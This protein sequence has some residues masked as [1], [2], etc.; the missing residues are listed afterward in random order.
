MAKDDRKRMIVVSVAGAAVTLLV[1]LSLTIGPTLIGCLADRDGL[2]A[3]L[4]QQSVERGLLPPGSADSTPAA[5]PIP[6]GAADN[7]A[8][9][10]TAPGNAQFVRGTPIAAPAR[11]VL[12]EGRATG[13]ARPVGQAAAE[14]AMV[15][16]KLIAAADGSL[17]SDIRRE[18]I[19]QGHRAVAVL[20][21]PL[22][23]AAAMGRG[24][25]GMPGRLVEDVRGA[26]ILVPP[27]SR[28]L[29]SGRYAAVSVPVAP[30]VRASATLPPRRLGAA[31]AE[32]RVRLGALEGSV[33][34]VAGAGRAVMAL[35]RLRT[36]EVSGSER[37]D[38]RQMLATAR[39]GGQAVLPRPIL[40]MGHVMSDAEAVPAPVRIRVASTMA[41]PMPRA[42]DGRAA[43][44][45]PSTVRAARIAGVATVSRLLLPATG[46]VSSAT[47]RVL[48]E[49]R[50]ESVRMPQMPPPPLPVPLTTPSVGPPTPSDA[51]PRVPQ[52]SEAPVTRMAASSGQAPVPAERSR[53]LVGLPETQR[54]IPASYAV[55]RGD[56]LWGISR[57]AYGAGRHYDVIF[58]ANRAV[59]SDPNLIF[60]GQVLVI[61]DRFGP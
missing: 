31:R 55:I 10:S 23:Q 54:R 25:F 40:A 12:A 18:A 15:M 56:T 5:T 48:T 59:I 17:R 38:L 1:V 57:R 27:L 26:A 44:I 51:P 8:E 4:R 45:L 49:R 61:P 34:T 42:V 24:A 37:S 53:P 28:T 52:L 60:P 46:S 16:R 21:P 11:L 58:A 9:E 39:A 13:W 35:P 50:T 22:A 6:A 41:W 33:P 43:T 19:T 36:A 30:G 20:R 3:C 47:E 2:A 7:S 14:G 32:G 29:L